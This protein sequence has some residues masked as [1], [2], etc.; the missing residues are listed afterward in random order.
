VRT[1]QI[2]PFGESAY[3]VSFGDAPS[4]PVSA[5]VQALARS[6]ERAAIPGI[7]AVVPAYVSVLVEFNPQI[8]A[9]AT[10]LRAVRQQLRELDASTL[11]EPRHRRIPVIYGGEYGPDLQ[12]VA[13]ATGLTPDQ[14]VERHVGTEQVVYMLGFS[15]GHPYLGD[16]P[17]ELAL[18]R[19]ATPRALVPKGS[20][21]IAVGQTVIY[22]QPTPGGWHL[23]GRTPVHLWCADRSPPAYL[24]A[25]DR[26]QFES[27]D[28]ADWTRLDRPPDDW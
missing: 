13:R 26:V 10:V 2:E 17:P 16:L 20:V 24:A 21:A 5:R 9:A 11:P 12:A 15:P 28:A 27:I 4:L 3:L 1:V 25:G 23:I 19:L 7:T 8:Q 14:V 22:T 6:L 18:P